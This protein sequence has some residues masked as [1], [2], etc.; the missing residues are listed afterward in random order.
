[1]IIAYF[2]I[3]F[4]FCCRIPQVSRI[5]LCLPCRP[6]FHIVT[7]SGVDPSQASRG[8][9]RRLFAILTDGKPA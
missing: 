1:M 6:W 9:W 2:I 7:P 5:S 4:T 8:E 3:F